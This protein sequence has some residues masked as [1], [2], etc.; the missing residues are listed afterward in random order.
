VVSEG[1]DEYYDALQADMD[2]AFEDG[3][4]WADSEPFFGEGPE[5]D[6]VALFKAFNP[7]VSHGYIM[8]HNNG[9]IVYYC[10]EEDL[11]QCM[12]TLFNEGSDPKVLDPDTAQ[13]LAI[14]GDNIWGR[15]YIR[16]AAPWWSV[17]EENN[18]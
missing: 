3:I 9:G 17:K 7:D 4:D 8:D 5:L 16:A 2:E 10:A 6:L 14:H 18:E 1:L 12:V 15:W 13:K 11:A